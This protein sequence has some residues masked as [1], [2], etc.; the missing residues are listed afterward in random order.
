MQKVLAILS[1]PLFFGGILLA[2]LQ[3]DA[4]P[5]STIAGAMVAFGLILFGMHYKKLIWW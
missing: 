2:Y 5:W 1:I 3:W 4:E